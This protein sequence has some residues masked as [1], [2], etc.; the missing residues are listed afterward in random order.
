MSGRLTLLRTKSWN[1]WNPAN[2]ERVRKDEEREAALKRGE[3]VREV[4]VAQARRAQEGAAVLPPEDKERLASCWWAGSKKRPYE[5]GPEPDPLGP[6]RRRRDDNR[7]RMDD[8]MAWAIDD[9]GDEDE[10]DEDDNKGRG[11]H[12]G[13]KKSNKDKDKDRKKKDKKKDKKDKKKD[14]KDKEKNSRTS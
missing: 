4:E 10:D 9:D 7:K 8:P 12:S 5:S 3:T 1:V 6:D 14:K 11:G 13:A 2:L